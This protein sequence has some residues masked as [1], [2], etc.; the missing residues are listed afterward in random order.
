MKH[1]ENSNLLSL[2][3][4][5]L[6][7]RR[8]TGS[9]SAGYGRY[10][11]FAVSINSEKGFRSC[12]DVGGRVVCLPFRWAGVRFLDLFIDFEQMDRTLHRLQKYWVEGRG[13]MNLV[14]AC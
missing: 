9:E 4:W 1:S 14:G 13:V 10:Q 2:P 12:V 6:S 5:Y 7:Q 8:L 3:C 11:K